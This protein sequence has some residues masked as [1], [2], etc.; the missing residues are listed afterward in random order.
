MGTSVILVS[1]LNALLMLLS[2]QAANIGYGPKSCPPGEVHSACGGRCHASCNDMSPICA[3]MC[4]PG[5]VCRDGTVRDGSGK[6][7]RN[8]DCCKGKMVYSDRGNDHG[9]VCPSRTRPPVSHPDDRYPGCFCKAGYLRLGK[10]CVRP[11]DCPK[12]RPNH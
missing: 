7:I 12:I 4:V 2:V 9:R 8:Q 5:C 10:K 11:K 3:A 1:S 6:C